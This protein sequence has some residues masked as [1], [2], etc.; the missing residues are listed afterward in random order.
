MFEFLNCDK[1]C[2]TEVE[3]VSTSCQYVIPTPGCIIWLLLYQISYSDLWIYQG[4]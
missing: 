2:T 1:L 3:Q 4:D